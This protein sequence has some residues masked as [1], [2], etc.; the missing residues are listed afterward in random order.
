MMITL[1][2]IS[3]DSLLWN[4]TLCDSS[5]YFQF[6]YREK[7]LNKKSFILMLFAVS[8]FW[9]LLSGNCFFVAEKGMYSRSHYSVHICCA[10][11]ILF[12]FNGE[13]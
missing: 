11:R 9:S 2:L 3:E 13:K 6:H 12:P 5:S 7:H 4:L 10:W 8:H 1:R